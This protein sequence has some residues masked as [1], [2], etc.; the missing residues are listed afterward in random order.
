MLDPYDGS[1]DHRDIRSFYTS[2]L[3]Y[4]VAM[5]KRYACQFCGT[6]AMSCPS[7]AAQDARIAELER[8]P[9]AGEVP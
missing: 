7:C 1:C 2:E 4:L 8:V 3:A 6:S 9:L 5:R